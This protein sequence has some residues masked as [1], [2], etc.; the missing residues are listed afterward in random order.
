MTVYFENICI[1][2]DTYFINIFIS[3]KTNHILF[4]SDICELVMSGGIFVINGIDVNKISE[5]KP[6]KPL[7]IYP[8]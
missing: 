6:S 2:C 5:L 7:S 8:W 1:S 4:Y 3:D